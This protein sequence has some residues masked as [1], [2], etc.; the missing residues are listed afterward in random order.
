MKTESS[1]ARWP[2]RALHARCLPADAPTCGWIETLPPPPPA[3]VLRRVENADCAVIGAGFTGLAAARRLAELRPSWRILL[4]DAQRA[5]DGASGRS[6]GFVVDLASFIATMAP[7]VAERFIHLSRAGIDALRTLVE[8]H[9]IACD[10][11]DRGWLHVAAGDAGRRSLDA[12]AAW[13]EGRGETFVAYDEEGMAAVA[14]TR[15]Y[16]AGLRLPG[17]ILVQAAAL[18]RGLAASLPPPVELFERSPVVRITCG[19]PHRLATPAGEVCAPRLVV[20]LN[21]YAPALGFLRRRIFPLHTFGSLSRPLSA[22]Q[23][24]ALGGEREWGL[25]AQDPLG[26]TL[27]RTRDQR[28][29]IRNALLYAPHHRIGGERLRRARIA[30]RRALLRRYPMLAGLE[31]EHTWSGAMGA[32]PNHQPFFGWLADGVAGAGGFTGAGIAMGTAC[33]LLLAHLIS[34][35]EHELLASA[36]R[37]PGPRWLPPEPFLGAGIRLRV[38][39]MNARAAD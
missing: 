24:E 15:F 8:E 19:R 38:A 29:L 32:S 14:G 33:G 37:L 22:A 11:D 2:R 5:G 27:R 10:W 28:L 7:P 12:L 21:A 30:H 1:A 34:G 36:L 16:R 18:A 31:I 20:A 35:E 3:R 26:A 17:S 9:R 39:W 13:L 23:Q 6:S 25:L 4:L